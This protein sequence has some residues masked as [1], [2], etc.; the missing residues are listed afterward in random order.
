MPPNGPEV[1]ALETFSWLAFL[2]EPEINENESKVAAE[3]IT[4]I[5]ILVFISIFFYGWYF[6]YELS[7]EGVLHPC[8]PLALQL[9]QCRSKEKGSQ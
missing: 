6:I 5:K 1:F 3:A 7:L 2:G 4:A 9:P 8:F